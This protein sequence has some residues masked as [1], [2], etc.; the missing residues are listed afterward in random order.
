M[1]HPLQMHR[2]AQVKSASLESSRRTRKNPNK[3]T[4]IS[5]KDRKTYWQGKIYV[6]GGSADGRTLNTFEAEVQF[7]GWGL[8]S[9]PHAGRGRQQLAI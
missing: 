9:K 8:W 1:R 3:Q 6:V 4:H 7:L 2:T 5:K